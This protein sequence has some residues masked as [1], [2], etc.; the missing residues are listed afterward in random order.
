MFVIY[1]FIPQKNIFYLLL[2][3]FKLSVKF[4]FMKEGP[5]SHTIM[6]VLRIRDMFQNEI[7]QKEN[8]KYS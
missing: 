7:L 6:Y 4:C 8:V 2:F 3:S 5:P 1:I